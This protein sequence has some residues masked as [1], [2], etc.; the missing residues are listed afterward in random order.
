MADSD[1]SMS[2]ACVTRRV[3]LVG[4][5]VGASGW[6]FGR[7]ASACGASSM[8]ATS[9]PALS[10]WRDWAV[11]HR[12]AHRLCRRQQ[13][14]EK[15]LAERVEVLWTVV[16]V[17]G[18]A[19]V[20]VC[21][22]EALDRLVGERTDMTAIRARAEA[23]LAERQA[24]F[25]AAANEIGYFEGAKAEREAFALVEALLDGLAKT[26]AVTLAGVV[27][28]LDAVMRNGEDWEDHSTFPWPQ[29]RSARQDLMRLSVQ[30]P[31]GQSFPG[32]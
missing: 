10:L 26:P 32:G 29:I 23:E 3:A 21:S 5:V 13:E 8:G 16:K 12:R 6:A 2:L 22:K 27:G 30:E 14:L 15:S 24:C 11:A 28:K 4:W 25:E 1:H 18:G 31:P 19:D 17:P 9:D 20:I 7:V